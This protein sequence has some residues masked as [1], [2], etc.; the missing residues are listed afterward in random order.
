MK[1]NATY[2]RFFDTESE[3]ADVA[4]WKTR[5]HA[6]GDGQIFCVTEGPKENWAVCDLKTAIELGQ[7]YSWDA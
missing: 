2:L 3:A 7:S 1:R 4:R 5:A 6:A